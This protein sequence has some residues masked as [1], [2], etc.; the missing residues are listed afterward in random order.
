MVGPAPA[1]LRTTEVD[2]TLAMLATGQSVLLIGEAGSGKTTIARQVGEELRKAGWRIAQGQYLGMAKETLIEIAE[3]IGQAAE[4][5]A[6]QIRTDLTP[7]LCRNQT[8]LIVDDAHQWPVS[9]RLWLE[10]S[11]L[12]SGAVLLLTAIAPPRS[13]IFLKLPR[14]EIEAWGE[15]KIR[16]V[17]YSE[18]A[19]I[20]LHLSASKAARIQ[21]KAG[22]N[23]LL[24][25][26]VLT[27]AA[28]ELDTEGD[29]REYLDLSPFVLAILSALSILRFIGLGLGDRQ[30]YLIGG[31][32]MV[33]FFVARQIWQALPRKRS[34]R[35][36]Q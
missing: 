20:G 23:P 30:L 4:G 5:S 7:D 11:L 15:E 34:A 8:L 36:G 22:G 16:S 27:E 32:T 9:I 33:I 1:E 25:K 12:P 24:A 29:H 18:A 35:L 26:R 14:I 31:I 13:G 21:A 2:R 10:K 17:L 19:R 6:A 28:H 3:S